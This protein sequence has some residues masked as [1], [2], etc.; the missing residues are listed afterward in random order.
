MNE[1]LQT[2]LS[3]LISKSLSGVDQASNFLK[4]EMPDVV[5]QLL[6]WHGVYNFIMF[7]FAI[8]WFTLIAIISYKLFKKSKS[9]IY[10]CYEDDFTFGLLSTIGILMVQFFVLIPTWVNLN[11]QWLQ[12]WVAPKVWLIEYAS[13][14]VK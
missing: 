14:L 10:K 1:Q 4:S 3:E 6:M 9:E 2:A 5:K 11:L 12:I 8:L 13:K 7:L